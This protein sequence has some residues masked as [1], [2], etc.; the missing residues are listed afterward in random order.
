[1]TLRN[2]APIRFSPA[3]LSDSLDETDLF[4]GACAVLQNLIPDPTTK[5][6]W[7]C[8]PAATSLTT[9]S[10]FTT[11]VFISA[12]SVIGSLV[13]GLIAS[14]RTVGYDEPFC[15]NIL[16]NAFVT[17]GGVTASNVPLS[18]ATSGDWVPPTMALC[19]VNLVVTHPGFDGV[20]NFIGWFDTSNPA[21]P[22]WHAGNLL[23]TGS[24]EALGTITPGSL[25]TAG[26]YRNVALTISSGTAGTGATADIVVAGGAVTSVSLRKYGTGY[27]ATS[28]LTATAASIGGT[29][30][31]FHVP[32]T[33][34]A[35]GKIL[36]TTPPAWVAQFSGRAYLGINPSVGQPSV[37]FTDSLV[38]TCS[39]AGQALTFGDNLPLTAAIG[40]PLNNQLG[41]VIQALLVFKGTSQI[42]Q[43]TGDYST[44][45]LALNTLNAATGTLA[46]L[47]LAPTPSGIG[48]L[49]PDGY[50]IIDFNAQVSDP[51]GVAGAGVNVPFLSP[52][53]PSRVVAACN[54]DVLRITV[55]NSN[56]NGTPFQ[57]YWFD[58]PRK[59]WSGPHTFPASFIQ[60][61]NNNFIVAPQGVTGALFQSK[62]VPDSTTNATENGVQL[63]WVFQTVMLADNEQM[64]MSEIA[65]MQV[66]TTQTT[67]VGSMTVSAQDENGAVYN[68]ANYF[69]AGAGS[70][71]GAMTWGSSVWGGGAN[72]LYPRRIGFS[73][74]V[75]YNRLAIRVAGASGQ[76]FKIGDLF[77]R[78]RILG[79][80]QAMG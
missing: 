53:Y 72:A 29:G 47:S 56:A 5:N 8:R 6:I 28:V 73:A 57:E 78:R 30:S 36:L 71:W 2:A 39:N 64:A 40:L 10:G 35:A 41:G 24:I 15:Y 74:P 70:Q 1:M 32:V 50:R 61:Y 23:G 14:G 7:T 44:T 16:T 9:F 62:T 52:L 45:N 11:P 42:Y 13:Y 77:I 51:I 27:D 18:P 26:T 34:V 54:A 69:F 75:I 46:P 63:Q 17:V 79:Y 12:F 80:M 33:A 66:K 58:L 20:T 59:V 38:L 3:G 25:Y 67:N 76:G 65:E 48:F 68:S 37:V 22:I 55:Q 21:A 19:G 31:G 49:A 4:P 60:E 43:I